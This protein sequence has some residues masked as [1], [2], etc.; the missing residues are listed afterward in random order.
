[1]EQRYLTVA[2][3][4][5]YIKTKLETDKHLQTILIKGEIS[6]FKRHNTG[7]FYFVIK[8]EEAQIS[9]M[10]FANLASKILFEPKDGDHVLIQATINLYAPRGTYSL[11]VYEMSLDGIGDLYLKYEALKKELEAKGYFNQEHKRA[12]PKFPKRIGV[13]TSNTG[14]VIEDIKNTVR[15]R[16]L[17]TEIYLYPAL[18]QGEYAKESIVKQ[19]NKA[20]QDNLVDTLI[21]GRGGGSIEDLWAFNEKEVIEAIFNSKIPVI[22]AIGHETDFTL[23]D[24][25]SDL[26]APTPTAAAE[27]ATPNKDD[28]LEKIKENKRLLNYH[29]NAKFDY[30]KQTILYLEERLSNLSPKR[31][32]EDSYKEL[33]HQMMYLNKNYE[34][35]ITTY[36][37]KIDTL[38]QKVVSPQEKIL[39]YKEQLKYLDNF[40]NEKYQQR[41]KDKTLSYLIQLEKLKGLDPLTFMNKGFA[42]VKMNDNVVTSVSNIKIKEELT[43]EFKDGFVKT[44]VK[45]KRE[46]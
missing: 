39:M 5:K 31:K 12:I 4:T 8:D 27:L 10:M 17:L 19:I 3:L 23:S 24:F 40:L 26:R 36:K 29:I 18:V 45:E 21:V 34:S 30:L 20:N 42:L 7:H 13:I 16:Y 37:H 22:T 11:N 2:A 32:I 28:L 6:N 38:T 15:R 41:I 33:N 46:K 9:A 14:A 43:I 25:V 35:I 1:M 44:I